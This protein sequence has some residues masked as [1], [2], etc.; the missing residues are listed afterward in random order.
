MQVY[1]GTDDDYIEV[2]RTLSR[3][4]R[5]GPNFYI[6]RG[7]GERAA[8]FGDPAP[9]KLKH[10]KIDDDMYSADVAVIINGSFTR[11]TRVSDTRQF[12]S[13]A[14]QHIAQPD[15]ALH[16]LHQSL[17]LDYGS[18]KE[19]YPEQLMTATFLSPTD[20]VLEIGGN[21]G[22]NSLIIG[23]IVERLVVLES[24]PQSAAKLIHNRNLNGMFFH[25]EASALSEKRLI[26]N[27]WNTK[28]SEV[29]EPGWFPIQTITYD[30]LIDK[31]G[32]RPNTLVVDCEGALY[33]ILKDNET[34]LEGVNLVIIENDFMDIQHKR[35]VD[36]LFVKNGL[37]RMY[38]NAGGGGPC[39]DFFYEVWGR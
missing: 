39:Y 17:R 9:G 21:I 7:E 29:D 35:F 38:S 26:Q 8:L 16:Y 19:E 14:G 33:D 23:S 25:V 11:V 12:W 28:P 2:G 22:R 18:M 27:G 37:K 13:E 24:D 5:V 1:Y 20:R 36:G 34:I 3:V 32:F 15:L 6:P 31:Y 30:R 10:I 4:S